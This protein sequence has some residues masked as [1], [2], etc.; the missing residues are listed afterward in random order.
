MDYLIQEFYN[1]ELIKH[2]EFTL[3][4]GMKSDTY[5]DMRTIISYPELYGMV[6]GFLLDRVPECDL[7]CG[8]PYAGIPFA[9]SIATTLAMP[10]IMKR[11][12][13]KK[14]GT[15]GIIIGDF[16]AGDKCVLIEDVITTGESL[17]EVITCLE[18]EGLVIEKILVIVDRQ[19]GGMEKLGNFN[20]EA[21][22]N[23]DM[24]KLI[25]NAPLEHRININK[26]NRKLIDIINT[27]RSNLCLSL[28]L[29]TTDEILN[30]IEEVGEHICMLKLHSDIIDDFNNDFVNMLI[31]M[32]DKY[33]FTIMEDRKFA[34]I[35]NIT[36]LQ[37]TCKRNQINRWADLVTVHGIT[38][39]GVFQVLDGIVL[40]YELSTKDNLIDSCY[41]R[42]CNYLLNK[43]KDKI[44]GV[45]CQKFV[46][47]N[48]LHMTPGV[49]IDITEDNID[50]QYRS[51]NKAIID[52]GCDIVIVGRGIYRADNIKE[53]TKE[54]QQICW[55]SYQHK[56]IP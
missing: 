2:G 19:Q 34:D 36:S 11:K 30:V 15:G 6:I 12:E 23:M 45:V 35:G 52:D 37:H 43:Y 49:N 42:K 50:Q 7:I 31:T 9:T 39:E 22:F 26:H 53:K 51:P 8:I 38:G 16:K 54:Y 5:I 41:K 33:N 13:I 24:L 27:K 20:I 3:K 18:K 10:F 32:K 48:I 47:N 25:R 56:L 44:A 17:L 40:V 55:D 28:D 21:L 1:K 4:S 14:Y 46:N 29:T